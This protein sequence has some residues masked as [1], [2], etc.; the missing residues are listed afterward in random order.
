VTT[1]TFRDNTDR[2]WH[3]NLSPDALARVAAVGPPLLTVGVMRIVKDDLSID[4]DVLANHHRALFALVEPQ[5]AERYVMLATFERV[6]DIAAIAHAWDAII[7][8]L[9]LRGLWPTAPVVEQ[10]QYE[11]DDATPDSSATKA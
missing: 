5:A 11:D 2:R 6:I 8:G 7:A 10:P 3:V 4:A 9:K 1:S